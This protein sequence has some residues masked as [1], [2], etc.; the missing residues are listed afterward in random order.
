[1]REKDVAKK[2]VGVPMRTIPPHFGH[3]YYIMTLLDHYDKVV[4]IIGSCYEH[5]DVRHSIS[6]Q[7]R[8]KMLRAM[9]TEAKIP[10]E[11]YSFEH[12][13]DFKDDEKWFSELMTIVRKHQLSC[14]AT[15]NEWIHEIFKRHQIAIEVKDFKLKYPFRYRATD[16]RNAILENDFGSLKK[17]VP[18]SVLQIVLT[19]DCYK[20]VILSNQ[21]AA[22]HFMEGRQTVDMVLLLKD[23]RTQKL[24]VLLG[25]R[26]QG[27]FKDVLALPGSAIDSSAHESPEHAI[28][29]IV[30]EE[31]GLLLK[32]V[33]KTYLQP[34][35]SFENVETGL[36]TMKYVGIYSS[37]EKAGSFGGSSQ[38]FS[39]YIEDEVEKFRKQLQA[40]EH[41]YELDFYEVEDIIQQSLA[42]QHDEMLE[43]AMYIS[44]AI[45]KIELDKDALQKASKCIALIGADESAKSIVAH[46][47]MY[48]L[49]C[50]GVDV[51]LASDF[52]KEERYEN[53]LKE[54]LSD[55][56]FMV[57]N[58]SRRISR[59]IG[60]VDFIINNSPLPLLIKKQGENNLEE[61]VYDEFAKIDN[62]I[63]FLKS[64]ED[65]KKKVTKKISDTV[66][67]SLRQ[68]GYHIVEATDAKEAI[69]L[70]LKYVMENM[71]DV[72][73]RSAIHQIIG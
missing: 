53:H 32:I 71:K 27:D 61:T 3:L 65:D 13:S 10:E 26:S 62:Y 43:R 23:K 15:G 73:C 56:L 1:M 57:G 49:K 24:Y 55:P 46:G 37:E 42:F 6:A 39:I 18:F 22:V 72:D 9:L 4:I 16:V 11:K 51:E 47:I 8:E 64:N 20:S 29:R 25:K 21:N 54:G 14:I 2:V 44:K 36:T 69:H 45:P 31:T 63:I 7:I 41:L 67:E 70:A 66:V 52:V 50:C 40:G 58:Q 60:K 33:D 30:R 17:M 59:L 12:L 48:H 68:R 28:V 34:P 35:V 19:N 38:C 5:G